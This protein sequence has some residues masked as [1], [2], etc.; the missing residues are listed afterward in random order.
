MFGLKAF[1]EGKTKASINP[2]LGVGAMIAPQVDITASNGV[3]SIDQRTRES[4]AVLALAIG[5]SAGVDIEASDLISINL[6]VTYL[7]SN[8]EVDQELETFDMNGNPVVVTET[9]DFPYGSILL[10]AG[11]GFNF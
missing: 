7:H 10:S 1:T 3:N 9:T 6:D 4:D 11:I 5:I 2:M 8:F